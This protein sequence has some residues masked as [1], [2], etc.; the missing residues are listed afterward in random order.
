MS[1]LI[2]QHGNPL[3]SRRFS[4]KTH[5]TLSDVL[6]TY[7]LVDVVP[8]DGD[9]FVI[10]AEKGYGYDTQEMFTGGEL[11]T[12]TGSRAVALQAP[13]SSVDLG[14]LGTSAPSPFTSWIR[15]EYNNDLLGFNGLQMYDKMRKSDG[16]IRGMLRTIKTPVVA[17]RWFMEPASESTQDKNKA[18]F[19][20]NC[21]TKYMSISWPQLLQEALL[22]ADFGYYMFEKVWDPRVIKGKQR[23]VWKKLAPRHPMDVKRWYYDANGGP[24]GVCMYAPYEGV[25][26][27]YGN[28]VPQNPNPTVNGQ[29]IPQYQPQQ[30]PTGFYDAN[31]QPYVGAGQDEIEIPIDKL[32]V[33]TFD[34]EAGNIEG[35]S[36][37]RPAYKHWYYK[38]QLYKIDAIQKERHGIG[39]PVIKLPPSYNAD[40][41]RIA[42]ELGRNLRTNERAHV[43][44]PPFWELVFAKLEGNP[45][46]ALA[47]IQLHDNA[48]RENVLA[49]FN[50]AES[51]T[52]EEDQT[53]F[54]KS[55]RFI[56][57]IVCETFNNYA[58]PQLIDN[59]FANTTEYPRLRVRRIGEQ[60]DQRTL[61][62]A[63][64]NLVGA[65]V[66][67]PDDRLESYLREEMDLP[68]ADP[69]TKREVPTPQMPGGSNSNNQGQP[70]S[71]NKGMQNT[72]Q[73]TVGMPRQGPPSAG[74]PGGNSG[75]DASGG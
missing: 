29:P 59:N 65:K 46:D 22:M 23:M 41:K 40:D 1:G 7:D 48:I 17:A 3:E 49:V 21:L 18:E 36:V 5:Q 2:D 16:T 45:V 31:G 19:A 26:F 69:L 42:N 20:W 37:L 11:T 39:I 57:E 9:P 67:V 6:S 54:L 38:E 32:L 55:T 63:V 58:I 24:A 62:F 30:Q 28:V 64:R 12:R 15:R 25:S 72:N 68:Q 43:V 34:R 4:M 66:I 14:E 33:F 60:V 8:N 51:T 73:N 53:M 50:G 75:R 56:G 70:G 47:S 13:S 10:V 27:P 71:N 61:S 52:K 35:M 44:L 74:L